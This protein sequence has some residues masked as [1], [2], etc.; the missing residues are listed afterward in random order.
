VPH[1]ISVI[2]SDVPRG[3]GTQDDPS[4]TVIQYHTLDGELLAERDSYA[5]ERA[6]QNAKTVEAWPR[7]IAEERAK[8]VEIG[9]AL[10][11]AVTLLRQIE[12]P[13]NLALA[14]SVASFLSRHPEKK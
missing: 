6:A 3:R 13:A 14:A 2:E 11:E 5:E 12:A 7:T 1:V 4:R 10:I 9:M 8:V